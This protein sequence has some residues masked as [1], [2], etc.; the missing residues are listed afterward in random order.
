MAATTKRPGLVFRSPPPEAR[1]STTDQR[2]RAPLAPS[3]AVVWLSAL[4]VV[5]AAVA[6][7]VGLFWQGDGGGFS[8]T[9][10]RGETVEIYGRGIYRY[11]TDFKGAGN[12]GTDAVTLLLG[13]PLLVIAVLRYR[14]GSLRGGLLLLGVLP[15]FLYVYTTAALGISYNNLF[16]VYVAL[17]S[18][19]LYA[20]IMLFASVNYAALRDHFS[21]RLPRRGLAVF[22]FVS[23]AV[24][25]AVWLGPLLGALVQGEPP[26]LLDS[27]TTSIT[28]ALDLGVLA[29]AMFLS[30]VLVLRRAPLGYLIAL[31]LL[32]LEAMLA[33]MIA[34]QTVSQ[35]EAGISFTTGEIAGPITGFV[36]IALAAIGMFIALYR[37]ISEEEPEAPATA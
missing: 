31:S 15:W 20:F 26:K 9:T 22:M 2:A 13:I 32:V 17:F 4:I 29:P 7:G 3:T 34:A 6:A 16:L 10:L 19:S 35:I 14:R 5:L 36:V 11:D 18:A 12:R 1:E 33:P 28:D 30:G 27:N 21:P 25:L 8:F 37:N 24:T 23:G